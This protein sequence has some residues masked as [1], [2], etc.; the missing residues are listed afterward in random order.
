MNFSTSMRKIIRYTTIYGPG[1]TWF[2]VAGRLGI[3]ARIPSWISNLH[4]V[5]V[6][7]CGQ[8]AFATI[9]YFLRGQS[10]RLGTCFDINPKVQDIFARSLG[11]AGKPRSIEEF[12]D[13]PGLRTIYIASNHATH[14]PYALLAL[15]RGIDT[16]IEKPIAVTQSQLVSLVKAMKDSKARIFAGYNRPFSGAIQMLRKRMTIDPAKGITLQCF[17]SGHAIAT[18]NWYRLPEEGSRVCGNVGHWL[19]L[20]VHILSW[21][22]IPDKMQI[23]LA[24]ADPGHPDD[25]IAISISTDRE[26]L[27]SVMLSTRAEPFEGVNESINFQHHETIAK[28]DDFRTITLWQGER[29]LRKRFWPKDVGHR[30]AI[31]QPFR[32]RPERDWNEIIQSTQLMLHITDMLRSGNNQSVF[33]FRESSQNL[34]KDVEAA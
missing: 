17:V 27:F 16:Y 8:F 4:D 33:S 14:T 32:I 31:L 24:I 23:K 30:D 5:G 1:R 6:I 7:G 34:V 9:G 3:V 19:D 11:V 13:H 2:K 28:I 29:L 15:A 18:D 20:F 21:R 26:D 25:N 12:L 10:H 22:G